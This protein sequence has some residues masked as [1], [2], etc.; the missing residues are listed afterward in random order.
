[1]FKIKSFLYLFSFALLNLFS[2]EYKSAYPLT[3]DAV[4]SGYN[5]PSKLE[6]QSPYNIFAQVNLL[7]LQPKEKGFELAY[8]TFSNSNSNAA[9]VIQ[10]DFDYKIGF[11]SAIGF[12]SLN[13]NLEAKFEYTFLHTSQYKSF[14]RP[15]NASG[16]QPILRPSNLPIAANTTKVAGK[17]KIGFDLLEFLLCKKYYIGQK[18]ISSPIIGIKSAFIDQRFSYFVTSNE[19]NPN[20]T[21]ANHMKLKSWLIG[22]KIGAHFKYLLFDNINVFSTPCYALT[23]QRFENI[24]VKEFSEDDPANIINNKFSDNVDQITNIFD[25]DFG[26]NYS[27]FFSQNSYHFD[28]SLS[29]LFMYYFNQ[30]MIRNLSSRMDEEIRT[31]TKPGDL[32]ISGLNFNVRF[33]F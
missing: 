9:R 32:I 8:T 1:M 23:F 15:S 33:D 5:Y 22:P 14:L 7:Y 28:F 11:R 16:M 13:D 25:F 20:I 6:L 2:Y 19:N 21:A 10:M 27:C 26:L 4:P 31:S 17:F 30:N 3:I 29:Y 18:L 24:N 12:S